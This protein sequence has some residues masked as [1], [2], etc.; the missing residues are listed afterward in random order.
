M[1]DGSNVL[2]LA[3]RKPETIE[4]DQMAF[5]ACR[6]CRNKTYTLIDQPGT[7]PLLRCAACGLHIGKI[8]WGND[9]EEEKPGAG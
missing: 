4:D 6:H 8:G 7:F 5:L 1:S 2:F 9:D 3:F